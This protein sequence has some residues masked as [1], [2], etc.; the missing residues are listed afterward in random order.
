MEKTCY[1]CVFNIGRV[2]NR[3][4][5][6]FNHTDFVNYCKCD[7]RKE[8]KEEE[9][10]M[11]EVYF[12]KENPVCEHWE[13]PYWYVKAKSVWGFCCEYVGEVPSLGTST[14]TYIFDFTEGSVEIPKEDVV[15]L[16]VNDHNEA[17][18]EIKE[19]TVHEKQLLKTVRF[20]DYKNK[21]KTND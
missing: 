2:F 12:Q 16:K 5:R 8:F 3:D 20:S 13:L 9:V 4:N 6:H 19:K 15:Y 10:V 18:V 21:G 14:T 11:S 17:F 1:T 7:E